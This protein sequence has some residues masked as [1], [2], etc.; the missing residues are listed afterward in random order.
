MHYLIVQGNPVAIFT[1]TNKSTAS[2]KVWT[3]YLAS[4]IA[5]HISMES[6]DE[7]LWSPTS[8]RQDLLTLLEWVVEALEAAGEKIIIQDTWGL[9]GDTDGDI[10]R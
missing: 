7:M 4:G 10:P 6:G 9:L 2:C 8:T 3:E 5:V 1:N